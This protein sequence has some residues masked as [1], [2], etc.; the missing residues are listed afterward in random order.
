MRNSLLWTKIVLTIILVW[1]RNKQTK[2]AV[3]N[4]WKEYVATSNILALMC[5]YYEDE[6]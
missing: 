3:K 1:S 5:G 2:L 6:P 4:E